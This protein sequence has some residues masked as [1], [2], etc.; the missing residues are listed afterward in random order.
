MFTVKLTLSKSKPERKLI[1][2]KCLRKSLRPQNQRRTNAFT[3]KFGGQPINKGCLKSLRHP[4]VFASEPQITASAE[5]LLPY[6][7][8]YGGNRA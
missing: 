2:P 8:A 3:K 5:S 1:R 7:D 4:F 6:P